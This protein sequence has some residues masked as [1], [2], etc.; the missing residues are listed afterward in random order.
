MRHH[1]KARSKMPS[2]STY[3]HCLPMIHDGRRWP[4]TCACSPAQMLP[5]SSPTR[6]ASSWAQAPR[7]PS[8]SRPRL[9]SSVKLSYPDGFR[10]WDTL[11]PHLI[12]QPTRIAAAGNKPKQIE[13]FIGRVNSGHDHL[14]VARMK[15]P[16]GWVEPGQRP[17]FQEMSVVLAGTA[18]SR[19]RGRHAGC[20]SRSGGR[21]RARRVGPLQHAWARRRRIHR[22]LPASILTAGCSS[23]C[24][25][26]TPAN[27][28][29]RRSPG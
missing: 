27:D 24:R 9:V 20:T 5:R 6:F 4:P 15:S 23:R 19:I 17:E 26:L 1:S 3:R 18:P 29:R 11:M 21:R 7:A 25:A 13:E 22:D 12:E 28:K 14:S 8:G 10:S 16:S 2:S